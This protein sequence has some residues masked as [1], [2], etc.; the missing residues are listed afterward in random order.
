MMKGLPPFLTGPAEGKAK[1][2]GMIGM[3]AEFFPSFGRCVVVL[4]LFW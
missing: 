1:G 4:L 2:G 3:V